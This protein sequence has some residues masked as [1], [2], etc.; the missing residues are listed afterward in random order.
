MYDLDG[1]VVVL[2]GGLGILGTAFSDALAAAGAHVVIADLDAD[3]CH[4]RA[5]SLASANG[6]PATGLRVDVSDPASVRE[7]ADALGALGLAPGVLINNAGAKSR[8]F[9]AP[10]ER[11]PLEDWNAVMA[12]NVTGVYLMIQAL[13]PGMLVRGRGTVINIGSIYGLR[14]P[15][16]RI[17]DGSDYPEMGGAINTPL[18]Y[19]ASKGAVSAITRHIAT[20]FG[21]QGIR[22]NTLVPG[23]VH[24]GQNDTFVKNYSA[25]TPA[26]RMADKSEIASA[27][28]FLASPASSYINGQ[29]LVVDGGLSAW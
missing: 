11:F 1:E 5:D 2:T 24:S 14:G 23:G 3:A 27:M 26:N 4:A 9:F 18:V 7:F 13:L 22:A 19:S 15:D 28:L 12:V 8:N 25:R 10:L 17:Y 29:D 16:Q 21:A 6:H 20:T